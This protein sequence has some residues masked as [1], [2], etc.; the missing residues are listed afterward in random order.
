[1]TFICFFLVYFPN[2]YLVLH[3][4]LHFKFL[5]NK[6]NLYSMQ[7]KTKFDVFV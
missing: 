1:V 6:S 4:V 3:I 7:L 2:I 5:Y